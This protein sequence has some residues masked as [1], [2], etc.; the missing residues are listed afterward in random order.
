M[1]SSNTKHV[2]AKEVN[3]TE[4]SPSV[5]IPWPGS[6]KLM[7][8]NLKDVWCKFSTLGEAVLL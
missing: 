5:S 6:V 4:P 1:Q 8:E 7:G 3:G 2:G